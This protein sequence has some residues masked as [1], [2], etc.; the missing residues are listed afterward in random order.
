MNRLTVRQQEVLEALADYHYLVPAQMVRLALS[1]STGAMRRTLRRFEFELPEDGGRKVKNSKAAIGAIR[2]GVDRES[3]RIARMYY[4]TRQG[5]ELVA[6]NRQT[7]PE[8]IFYPRGD[9][10]VLADIPHRSSPSISASSS[11]ATRRSTAIR[12]SSTTSTSALPARTAAR[13]PGS[14]SG[15]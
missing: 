2:A 1:K 5:A 3:G 11:T 7:D 13:K 12:S 6:E 10:L 14:A 9:R 15:N 8:L 4:L